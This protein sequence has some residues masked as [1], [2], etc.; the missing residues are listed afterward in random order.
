M[1]YHK[2]NKGNAENWVKEVKPLGGNNSQQKNQI[3]RVLDQWFNHSTLPIKLNPGQVTSLCIN[4]FL[5]I[6]RNKS[7]LIL[8]R[9]DY[10]I[11]WNKHPTPFSPTIFKSVSWKNFFCKNQYR[12]YLEINVKEMVTYLISEALHSLL[13][14]NNK[15][16]KT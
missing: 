10:N 15:K 5:L 9:W 14:N 3:K 13:H 7:L 4:N 2:S 11:Q 12:V 16:K 8:R 1:K 6:D